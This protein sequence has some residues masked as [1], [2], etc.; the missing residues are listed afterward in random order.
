MIRGITSTP[1][2]DHGT[3]G[4]AGIVDLARYRTE[5]WLALPGLFRA[6]EVA[7]V[8]AAVR[9]DTDLDE[10]NEL[11]SGTMRFAS[12]VYRRSATVRDLLLDPRILTVVGALVGP[13]AWCRWDQAVLKGPGAG[14]FPWHQDNGYTRLDH[15]HL[16]IWIALTDAPPE[17]G[18]LW[19]EP[20]GHTGDRE[21]RWVGSHVEVVTPPAAT[22]PVTARAGDVVAFSS[23][24]P[25]ATSPNTTALD[26][27]VYVAEFLP[28]SVGDPSVPPPHL[29]VLD[30]GRP[31]GRWRRAGADGEG[32]S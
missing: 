1:D 23:R 21:H 6:D 26:R 17:R 8:L 30:D 19:V 28:C 2:S 10:A 11:S 31:D 16:Q 18:G 9:A 15:E 13:S 3:P 7:T 24:L 27:W 32:A 29:V 25:H 14:T 5:G 22:V 4:P 20:G 12:N